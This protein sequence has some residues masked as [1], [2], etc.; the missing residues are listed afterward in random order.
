M[1]TSLL[2]ANRGE[3]ACRIIRTARAMGIRTVAVYSDADAKALHVRQADEAVH[4]G[5]S[6]ARESYLVGEKIIAAAKATGAEAIH[7]GYGFL[8]E[9]AEF[10]QAVIDAGLIWVGPKPASI[11]AMGLKDAAKKLMAEAGVPVTPGYLG[12]NQDPAFLAERAAEIGYPVLIKAVAGGGG[13]GM[14]KVDAAADF[15]DALASCQ[16]EATSSFGNPHVLIEKY[17]QRPRHIEVQ[18]FGDSHGNIVHLFERDC[19]LQRRHQKVIEE[20]PAPGMDE[21]TREQLCAAAVKAA[22]AVDYVGA[23]TIEFIADASEGLRADRIWFME[24]NTRLQVEHPVTEEITG[25]DL[26]EW[27]LRVASGEALPKRQDELSIHGWAMEARLYAEDPAKG[28]LPS[29]GKLEFLTLQAGKGRVESG[30]EEGDDVSPFYD[31]M[32]AKLIG[33]GHCREASI[34]QLAAK[35]AN[36]NVWPVR[37]NAGFLHRALKHGEFTNASLD[38]D[39]IERNLETL[40]PPAQPSELALQHGLAVLRWNDDNYEND[41]WNGGLDGLRLNGVPKLKALVLLDGKPT[42][43]DVGDLTHSAM[44]SDEQNGLALLNESG[45]TFAVSPWRVGGGS[46]HHAHDGDILSPM[47]G[48]IIAVEVTAGQTVTKGQKLVTLEAMKMEHSLTAPFDGTVAELNAEAGGQVSEGTL[49]VRI[50][51]AE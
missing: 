50:E 20:A 11:T 17:I 7:P 4:I 8:S 43:A 39:F 1:I 15:A 16:R 30:V 22:K 21:A 47:P 6:P 28:F 31:P 51:K 2:I 37:T 49:L 3:I 34:E 12:E 41:P 29:V 38:T 35:L 48:R 46:G 19:S 33:V 36:I 10:A 18:I 5:P 14:R 42:E 44:R 24:M 25:I 26:V 32:I 45:Q 13:K 23:G 40:L 9:N 27:Q